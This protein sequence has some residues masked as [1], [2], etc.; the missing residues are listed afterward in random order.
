MALTKKLFPILSKTEI[1]P[2]RQKNFER[3]SLEPGTKGFL[4]AVALNDKGQLGSLVKVQA[5]SREISYN[6]SIS[7]MW[8]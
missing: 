6:P 7:V 4:V 3:A 1:L 8:Q 2:K 5:D